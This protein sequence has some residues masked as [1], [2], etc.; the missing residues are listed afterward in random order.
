MTGRFDRMHMNPPPP[1]PPPPKTMNGT[2]KREKIRLTI[3]NKWICAP[4]TMLTTKI[5]GNK[6][7]HSI[8]P[9]YAV[10]TVHWLK[11]VSR[12]NF[13][14]CEFVH[15][16]K[17][18]VP[19]EAKP[20][21]FVYVIYCF[22][23]FLLFLIFR[24]YLKTPDFIHYALIHGHLTYQKELY[25]QGGEIIL[26][27]YQWTLWLTLQLFV[28]CA[29]V[30]YLSEK[31]LYLWFNLFWVLISD[32]TILQPNRH[33]IRQDSFGNGNRNIFRKWMENG[34]LPLK[35][36]PKIHMIFTA[37]QVYGCQTM[38]IISSKVW[39]DGNHNK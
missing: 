14:N 9:P 24:M 36:Y 39:P 20:G 10:H 34:K 6:T 18:K 4:V 1:S 26:N 23:Y 15:P 12:K 27:I 33:P 31:G 38:I 37:Y 2:R 28:I 16:V 21:N 19:E 13:K 35:Y 5:T 25:V 8:F 30:I 22:S 29:N 17:L 11:H 3:R 7:S 32:A